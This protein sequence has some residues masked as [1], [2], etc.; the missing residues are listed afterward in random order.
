MEIVFLSIC[1]FR[2]LGYLFMARSA[3][4]SVS[5]NT[6]ITKLQVFVA[7]ADESKLRARP[8]PP[9]TETA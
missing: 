1:L 6:D 4:G 3:T 8:R 5:G 9:V 2:Y 7:T